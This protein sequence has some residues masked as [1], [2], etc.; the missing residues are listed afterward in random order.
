MKNPCIWTG[1]DIFKDTQ[2]TGVQSSTEFSLIEGWMNQLWDKSIMGKVGLTQA[3]VIHVYKQQ[4]MWIF[5]Q[6][7]VNQNCFITHS[8]VFC[9]SCHIIKCYRNI[10]IREI[11]L[12]MLHV[13]Q[14]ALIYACDLNKINILKI[15]KILKSKL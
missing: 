11:F 10:L 3:H 1:R 6:F 5:T 12:Y 14:K 9:K 4:V 7:S 8:S 15:C 2:S 13:K